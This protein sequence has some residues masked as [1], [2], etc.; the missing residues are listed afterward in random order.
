MGAAR[1]LHGAARY[2]AYATGQAGAVAHVAAHELGAAAYPSRPRVLP[3]RKAKVRPRVDSS[4]TGSVTN[5]P[6][7]FA[8]SYST[9]S[10]CEMTS[11]GR[12]L[13]AERTDSKVPPLA[14]AQTP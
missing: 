12:C 13:T 10:G 6:E 9:T 11:A 8:N 1:D 2:A 7:G 14:A 5:F 4:P 3:H